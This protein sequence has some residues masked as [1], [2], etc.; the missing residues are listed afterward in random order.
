VHLPSVFSAEDA[1]TILDL[2]WQ[3]YEKKHAVSRFSSEG[4]FTK[5]GSG[6]RLYGPPATEIKSSDSY[7]SMVACMHAAVDEVLGPDVWRISGRGNTTVFVNCPNKT[8]SW[9]VPVGWHTDMPSNREDTRPTVIYAF[10]FLDQLEPRGGSTMI[11]AGASRRAQLDDVAHLWDAGK[12]VAETRSRQFMEALA[13]ED[14]WFADLFG[15]NPLCS[16]SDYRYLC[17]PDTAAQRVQRFMQDG[18]YSVGI[19]MRVTELLGNPGDVVLWDPR[20][21]H[22]SSNNVSHRPRSAIRFRYDRAL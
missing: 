13:A 22:A 9:T 6:K 11:L 15:P 21:L 8:D 4:W 10:T 18:T 12:A 19:P 5:S 16:V 2:L 17:N 20:C 1:R 3:D 14:E 7:K